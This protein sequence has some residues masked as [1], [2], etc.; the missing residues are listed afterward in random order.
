MTMRVLLALHH[1]LT[2]GGGAPGAT[3]A[4]GSALSDLGCSVEYFGY[5]Q[6]LGHNSTDSIASSIKF[7]WKL[8]GF[9]KHKAATFDVIDVSTGD[10]WVWTRRGRPGAGNGTALIT[11]SHGLEHTVD[12]WQ[13]A[14]AAAGNLKLSWKYP[15]YHGGFR[16]WEVRQSLLQS[17]HNLL[18]NESDRDYATATLGVPAGR[19]SLVA[20]GIGAQFLNL[21][22]PDA[23]VTPPD[24][25]PT[26]PI[27]LAMI[28]TWIERK[29]KRVVVETA[30]RLH[31][32]G[33]ACTLTLFGTGVDEVQVRADFPAEVRASVRVVPRYT[34]TQLPELLAGQEVLLMC[35]FTEGYA[36]ALPEAMACGLAPIA[37][38]VGGASLVVTS[39]VNGELVE[40]GDSDA[41]V[42]VITRW[43]RDRG[44]LLE[45]RRRARQTVQR[46]DW[47]QIAAQ[48]VEIYEQVL[49]R[50]KGS[51]SGESIKS[52]SLPQARSIWQRDGKPSLSIC[53]C[54]ANRP[55]VLRRC[56]ASI[57]LGESNPAEVVVG[58][59][60]LDG[61]ETAAICRE[62]PFVR[63]VRGPR[64]GLC[65]NRNVVI[66][67]AAGD[68]L[69]LLDDDAEVTPA[70][71]RQAQELIS[72]ADGRTIFT[73]DVLEDG[74]RL[75]APSNPTF[76]GHFG[77]P[78]ATG[79]PVE[80][81]H[82]NCNIFPRLA[83][84]EARFDER[85]VYGYEDM[86]L[87]QQMLAAGF[88]IEHHPG[89]VNLHLPP[90]KSDS[91]KR[92]RGQQAE[93]ARYYTSLKRYMLWQARPARAMAY[94]A[95]APMH[96]AAHHL[97]RRQVGRALISFTDMTWAVHQA[98]EARRTSRSI[99]ARATQ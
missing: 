18:L 23:A 13:R 20:N 80:T 65:A 99:S 98:L 4:L 11:R 30:A 67:A 44:Q 53:I 41:V 63:Y 70:F 6:A 64:Q 88:R 3:L 25:V 57:E 82:L 12:R 73:G 7:P 48:T 33:V 68:Y 74:V 78:L 54:T 72:N 19:I 89:M 40:P 35:S 38:R 81:V 32:A 94:A 79:F 92:S 14:E 5:E 31:R 62:F 9:L 16:L 66:A 83:F 17:D 29:G 45:L 1:R 93:R 49:R 24:G 34:N 43:S 90:P 95:L 77:R 22:E 86:D 51:Q 46:H 28:G 56:L 69:S 47:P 84:A 21:P 36:L 58:D 97:A 27:R 39:G 55:A 60:S 91:I 37:T 42:E 76:W 10:N 8:A 71:V 2:P 75:V 87:C 26:E 59:D 96:Q 85:I 52:P 15:L 61:S 50:L